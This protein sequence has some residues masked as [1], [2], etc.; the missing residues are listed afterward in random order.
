MAGT[1]HSCACAARVPEGV[2]RPGQEGDSL[3]FHAERAHG[4]AAL[5]D[6]A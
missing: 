2:Q 5:V 1:A 6:V 4:R 3:E